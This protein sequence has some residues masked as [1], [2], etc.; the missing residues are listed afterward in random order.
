MYQGLC[1]HLLQPMLQ[2]WCE[3][4]APP[5]EALSGFIFHLCFKHQISKSCNRFSLCTSTDYTNWLW[6]H[7]PGPGCTCCY[8]LS[9][10]A[11]APVAP[12]VPTSF[13]FAPNV[14]TQGF[15]SALALALVPSSVFNT[16]A[17]EPFNVLAS[18]QAPSPAPAHPA[19]LP[20]GPPAGLSLCPPIIA[21]TET[22][23][24]DEFLCAVQSP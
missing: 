8:W 10:N 3:R 14:P 17:Q 21:M 15:F 24:E 7:H 11:L 2:G 18:A 22:E 9:F 12:A 13:T 6:L 23:T 20:P 1:W 19:G 5:H 16:L 4:K